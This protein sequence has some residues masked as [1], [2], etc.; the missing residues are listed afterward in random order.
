MAKSNT[1]EYLVLQVYENL[2]ALMWNVLW[3]A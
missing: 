1:P 3:Y 2:K